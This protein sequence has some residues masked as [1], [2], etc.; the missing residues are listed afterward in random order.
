MALMERA[1]LLARCPG[2]RLLFINGASMGV[3]NFH[4]ICRGVGPLPVPVRLRQMRRDRWRN[5]STAPR[6]F[7]SS[8]LGEHGVAGPFISG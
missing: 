4:P 5:A 1:E 8:L 2:T 7:V 6:P 3:G